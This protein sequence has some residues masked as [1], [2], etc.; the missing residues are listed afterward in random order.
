MKIDRNPEKEGR[1][2]F[3]LKINGKIRIEQDG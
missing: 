2:F 3:G 1:P